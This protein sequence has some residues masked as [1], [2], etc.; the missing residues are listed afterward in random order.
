MRS[1][2]GVLLAVVILW[3]GYVR[4]TNLG[5]TPFTSDELNHYYASQSMERGEGPL[6]PSGQEFRRGLDVTRLVGLTLRFV[7]SPERAVR[8]PSAIFGVLCLIVFAAIAWRLGGPWVAVWST[9]ILSIYPE[10]VIQSRHG[11]FYAFQTLFGLF[12]LYAGWMALRGAGRRQM[13]DVRSVRN[14]WLWAL[15]ALVALGLGTRVQIVTLAVVAGWGL[16]LVFAAWADGVARGWQEW[17]RSMPLQ[18]TMLGVLGLAALL[19]VRTDVAADLLRQTRVVAWW[20]QARAGMPSP[21]FYYY[22][23]AED[24][25][26]ALSFAPLV[27]LIVALRDL[28]MGVFLAAWFGVPLFLHSFVFA[29]KGDRFVQLAMPAFFLAIGIAAALGAGALFRATRDSIAKW[30]AARP[31]ARPAASTV[32]AV[33]ALALVVTTPAFNAARR[34]PGLDAP[35]WAE[36]SAILKERTDLRGLPLGASVPTAGLFYWGRVDFAVAMGLLERFG[37]P[38]PNDPSV[39]EQNQ[40]GSWWVVMGTPDYYTGVPVLTTPSAIQHRFRDV[41]AVL[42]AIDSN[43]WTY[44]NIEPSLRQRLSLDAE[45]LCAHRCGRLMLFHWRFDLHP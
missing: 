38:D 9:L 45:E 33:V 40:E 43:R 30:K 20:A 26:V 7:D 36:V 32:V 3:G 11:R 27:F 17:R 31:Y 28:R 35:R 39:A 10:A 42:I 13:P 34:A 21:L 44:G 18:L 4:L 29:W 1:V 37:D 14:S 8:L 2:P 12:A 25:P 6:L 22:G 23:L 41:G 24:I 15:A 16:C 19:I 5:G